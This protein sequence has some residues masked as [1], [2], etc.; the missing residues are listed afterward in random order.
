[1]LHSLNNK[2][3]QFTPFLQTFF[4][5]IPNIGSVL[6]FKPHGFRHRGSR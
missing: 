6:F 2:R 5:P 3:G 1:M 4:F